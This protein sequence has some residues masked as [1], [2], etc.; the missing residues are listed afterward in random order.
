MGVD[1]KNCRLIERGYLAPSILDIKTR[2]K[3]RYMGR[4]M[5]IMKEKGVDIH[6]LVERIDLAYRE[7]DG[8][9]SGERFW[10]LHDENVLVLDFD[11]V[12]K[13]PT[14]V[15]IDHSILI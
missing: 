7:L 11:P 5:R 2:S 10:D 3:N 4:F 6:E 14:L 13:K 15:V 1:R 8:M 12:T 9:K